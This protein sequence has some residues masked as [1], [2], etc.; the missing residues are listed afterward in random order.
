MTKNKSQYW[1]KLQFDRLLSKSLWKQFVV[2]LF[3]LVI[4]LGLSYGL[5][6]FSNVAW[7]EFCGKHD[8]PKW[9]LPIYLLIDSN[10]LN[11]LYVSEYDTKNA[12]HGWMLVASTITFICGAFVFNGIIIGIIT[13]SIERR[14]SKH[15]KGQIHYLKSGHH[16]I[17]GYDDMVPSIIKHIFEIDNDA[18]ILI[19]SSLDS[20][21]IHEKLCKVF[22][23]K[24]L[25]N[26]IINYGHI[27]SKEYYKDIH[28]ESAEYIY[29]V[30][31]RNKPTHD[32]RNVECVDSICDYLEQPS[33][34][35]RPSRI[36]CVFEDLDTYAAFK[37]SEIF[38]RVKDLDIEFIPYNFYTGWAKQVFVKQF[39]KDKADLTKQIKYP[40][41]YGKGITKDD[42]RYVHLVFVGT[43]NFAAAF[44]MEAAQVLHFPNGER[45]KTRISFIDL[46]ADV[47]KD[48][49][50]VRNRHLF[51]IQP[52]IYHDLTVESSDDGEKDCYNT[53]NIYFNT[54]KGYEVSDSGFLD[55]EFEFIKG[56]V[57]SPKVQNLIRKWADAHDKEQYLSIFLAMSN[58]QK[59][60]ALGMNMPDAVYDNG[61]PIFIRQ[62]RSDNFVSNLRHADE[63]IRNNTKKN[64]Y[65]YVENNVLQT[66]ILAGRYAHIY[67]FGM[68]DTAYS[69]D[70]MTL[71]CA[72]LINYLYWTMPS[73]NHFQSLTILNAISDS[74][75]W[76]DANM[77]WKGLTVALKWSNLYNAYTI[78]LKLE[79]LRAQRGLSLD[80]A[81]KDFIALTNDEINMLAKVEHNRWNVEKLLMGYRKPHKKEDQY[82]N[83]DKDMKDGLKR[84]KGR[85]IHHD[86]RPYGKLDD[87]KNLDKEFSKYIPWI[88]QIAK[89][90][91]SPTLKY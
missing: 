6:A 33:I 60:F 38:G 82:K 4:L 32:A 17:M 36:T 91:P 81:S 7:T 74:Q 48:E 39:H 11:N 40:T 29:I 9:L 8:I 12:V 13:N 23:P 15:K 18:Y 88:I 62:D 35:S 72:K 42:D 64:T 1:L 71:K 37:T 70:D 58:E 31:Q 24:Q 63:E 2:L 14:V 83:E 44:A 26:I 67:P 10:A 90:Y 66:K 54:E 52:Y 30:G 34:S 20:D 73:E 57:F 3:F 46:N 27:V 79:I 69:A 49:F 59:N 16:I 89:N 84:N 56:N 77:Y 19:L 87:V 85:F 78:G 53:E 65:S 86:I 51:E 25:T 41:V 68:N 80:D 21:Y 45:K 50:I 28:L 22:G 76:E 55:V 5:L 75:V 43:T 61:V 47:E